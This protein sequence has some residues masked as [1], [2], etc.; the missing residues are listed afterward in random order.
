[1]NRPYRDVAAP[2]WAGLVLVPV[3]ILLISGLFFPGLFNNLT[4]KEGPVE[5]LTI[6]VALTGAGVALVAHTR[7]RAMPVR[8]MRYLPIVFCAGFIFIA[9]EESSWGQHII[10]IRLPGQPE[11]VKNKGLANID[12]RDPNAIQGEEREA[13]LQELNWL[14]RRND[15]SENNLHNLPGWLGNVF[16][17]W[18]K[19]MIE[20]GSIFACVIVPVFLVRRWR[21]NNP[22][23]LGYWFW[24]THVCAVAAVVAFLLPWPKRI[25]ET[26][27]DEKSPSMLR[28]SEPQEL[29]LTIMLM[30]Y[31]LSMTIRLKQHQKALAA[32]EQPAQPTPA[33]TDASQA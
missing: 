25:Y 28:L 1:M 15:Q 32:G 2:I 33:Q 5:W 10:N 18:P 6:L 13:V 29:Y 31:I 20:Y 8:W 16:A 17:K 12:P 9:G 14:Q 21:L 11:T 19:Q 23:Q 27:I 4:Y 24:P 7:R 30:L 26:F 3:L 22:H